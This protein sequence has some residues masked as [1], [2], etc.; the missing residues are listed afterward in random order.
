MKQI[1]SLICASML[2]LP[3]AHASEVGNNMSNGCGW[4]LNY[5]WLNQIVNKTPVKDGVCPTLDVDRYGDGFRTALQTSF[6]GTVSAS[7]S[8]WFPKSE[9]WAS[10]SIGPMINNFGIISSNITSMDQLDAEKAKKLPLTANELSRWKVKDSAYWESQGGVAFYLGAGKDP[11]GVG[12]FV[13]ATGGWANYLEKSGPNK[14]YVERAKKYVKS[15][16]LGTGVSLVSV[17]AELAVEKAKGFNYEMD[18][19]SAVN[20]Q[21]FERFMAGDTTKAYELSQIEGSGIKKIADTSLSKFGRGFGASL[22]TPYIPIISLR[23]STGKDYNHEEE[24]SI[25]DEHVVKDYGVYTRQSSSRL[26]GLHKKKATS[27]KG[28]VVQLDTGSGD[29]KTSST[30]FYGN[31]KHAYQSD[32]GQEGRLGNQVD[33]AR[34]ISGTNGMPETCVN[35]P[36]LKKSLGYN[37]VIL[38]MN[39]SDEYMRAILGMSAGPEFLAGIEANARVMDTQARDLADCSSAGGSVSAEGPMTTNTEHAC[40]TSS[41]SS[42]FSSIRKAIAKINSSVDRDK[43]GFAFGMANLGKAIWSNPSVFRAFLEKGKS[44]GMDFNFEVSGQRLSR[45]YKQSKYDYSPSCVK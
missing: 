12:A 7:I 39:L 8:K 22:S 20:Q 36:N 41:V 3:A 45:F 42:A 4:Y 28:G 29:K 31:F 25:W 37:Q 34:D 35:V 33:Y 21:A 2:A 13:V 10:L 5:D 9:V 16:N 6:Y 26:V 43:S 24:L 11:V 17:G 38:Q 19:T 18:L 40:R 32:W 44:C 27:F 15:V 1:F 30:K 23:A 14:V